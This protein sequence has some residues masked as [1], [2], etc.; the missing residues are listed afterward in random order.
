MSARLWNFV[1][2]VMGN[3]LHWISWGVA[4]VVI[5]QAIIMSLAT[6]NPLIPGLVGLVGVAVWVVGLGLRHF[7]AGRN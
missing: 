4:I 6:G 5:A 3:V 2:H 1:R 7:F